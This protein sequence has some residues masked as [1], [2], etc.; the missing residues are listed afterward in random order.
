MIIINKGSK[1][2]SD[3]ELQAVIQRKINN[4]WPQ[5]KRER[6]LRKNDGEFNTFMEDQQSALDTAQEN[7]LFNQQLKSYKE[8]QERLAVPTELNLEDDTE[9]RTAAQA[10]VDTTPQN[11]KDF[12]G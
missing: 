10:V 11:V 8:A 6:S 4:Q 12:E 1:P 3:I 7:N 5:W 9:D 2:L